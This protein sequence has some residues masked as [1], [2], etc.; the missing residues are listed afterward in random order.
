M[1][2]MECR[3]GVN[4]RVGGAMLAV[5]ACWRTCLEL[6]DRTRKGLASEDVNPPVAETYRGTYVPRSPVLFARPDDTT[7]QR[8]GA[9]ATTGAARTGAAPGSARGAG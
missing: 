2:Q 1:V 9:G 8:L 7:S 5:D 3:W 4:E 6:G